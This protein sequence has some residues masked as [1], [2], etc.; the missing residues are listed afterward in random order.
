MDA[1]EMIL[2]Q[3]ENLTRMSDQIIGTAKVP[4]YF[5]AAEALSKIADSM[6]KLVTGIQMNGFLNLGR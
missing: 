5:Q 1:R 2:K 4:E 3:M 6:S